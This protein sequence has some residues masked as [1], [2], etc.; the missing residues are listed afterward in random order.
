MSNMLK[1]TVPCPHCIQVGT[2]QT[3]FSNTPNGNGQSPA[4][5]QKCH[6]TFWIEVKQG[7]VTGTHK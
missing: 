4:Q 3:G 1:A 5:C 7:H 6:K 2:F